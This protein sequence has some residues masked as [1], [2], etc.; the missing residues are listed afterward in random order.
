ML[1]YIMLFYINSV[2]HCV[3]LWSYLFRGQADATENVAWLVPYKTLPPK[4]KPKIDDVVQMSH[5]G[6]IRVPKNMNSG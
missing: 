5:T 6:Q 2:P 4:S 3:V 1:H